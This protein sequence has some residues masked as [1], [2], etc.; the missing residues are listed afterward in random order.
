MSEA[1]HPTGSLLAAKQGQCGAAH[2][3]RLL[4]DPGSSDPC[5]VTEKTEEQSW[6]WS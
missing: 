2:T 1:G 3:A 4:K 6:G 5:K